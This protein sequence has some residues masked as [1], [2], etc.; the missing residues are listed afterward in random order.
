MLR[1][2][3]SHHHR[4]RFLV[5]ASVVA[6]SA[7]LLAPWTPAAHAATRYLDEVFSSVT[8]QSNVQYGSS[9]AWNGSTVQLRMDIRR[10]TG[11][12]VTGRPAVIW[13]HGGYFSSGDKTDAIEVDM[14]NRFTKRGFVTASI[15]YRLRSY[16][17]SAPHP[18][19]PLA[20]HDAKH[21]MLAAVR[22]FRANAT[23]L[24]I[25]PNKITVGGFSAGAIT[26][27]AAV[28]NWDDA[29]TS[30]N[31]GWSSKPQA[32]LSR[33]G[34]LAADWPHHSS[35]DGAIA[36]FHGTADTVV[37][38]ASAPVTCNAHN[39]AG[40]VCEFTAYQGGTHTLS[41][42]AEDI[43]ERSSDFMCRRVPIGCGVATTTTTTVPTTTTTTTAPASPTIGL[44]TTTMTFTGPAF[45]TVS[46]SRSVTITNTGSGTLNWTA[47][48]SLAEMACSPTSGSRGAGTSQVMTCTMNANVSTVP[49]GTYGPS[50]ITITASGAS[51]SPRTIQVW[52]TL[53]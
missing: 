27:L 40:S 16:I 13:A 7:Q 25:D 52:V 34:A 31:P 38:Y 29:G 15:N 47:S 20:M 23:T 6:L 42:H 17:G 26:S 50:S 53:T 28:T 33:A 2:A 46:Q 18:D 22:Y 36:M 30:G 51:N 21:D 4:L 32:A 11:D 37:P 24:G 12:S 49:P 44:N 48:E 10:P 14:V 43:A 5:A 3:P 1:R 19:T 39:A 9:V 45:G 35:A 41:P 8:L